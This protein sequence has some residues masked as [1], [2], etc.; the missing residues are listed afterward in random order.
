[1]VVVG[2][3]QTLRKFD[4]IWVIVGRLTK[5]AHF[6]LVCTTYSSEQL[7]EIYIRKI[8]RLHGI[9][10]SI[11]SDR[12]TQFTSRFWRVVQ[13]ELGTRVELSTAFHP[14]M[15]GQSEHTIQILEDILRA[16]V[17]EFGGS[18][19]QFLPLAEFAYNNSYR[20][21]I[22]MAPCWA[23]TWFRMLWKRLR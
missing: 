14:Q 6:I 11:I 3:P 1:M 4:V 22:Q 8:V 16:C 2:L 9:P 23:Q 13:Y 15:D 5:S 12:D 21:S 18:W 7:A 10:V 19:D 20:S 17:I